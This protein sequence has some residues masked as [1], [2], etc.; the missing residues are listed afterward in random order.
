MCCYILGPKTQGAMQQL[1]MQQQQLISQLQLVQQR[2]LLVS[3]SYCKFL[4]LSLS[5]SLSLFLSLISFNM[6]SQ[7]LFFMYFQYLLHWLERKTKNKVW[8]VLQSLSPIPHFHFWKLILVTT[9]SC[10]IF[11]KEKMI[12]KNEFGKKMLESI[13]K[14]HWH[15]K[16][17]RIFK[18]RDIYYYQFKQ[19]ILLF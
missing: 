8:I 1:Q 7:S 4:P 12:F 16:T 15:T 18:K 11:I 2:I 5:L 13:Y 9:F 19:N 10:Q 17:V 14:K 6:V 3:W